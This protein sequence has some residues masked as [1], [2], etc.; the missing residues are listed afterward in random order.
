MSVGSQTHKNKYV[1][2]MQIVFSKVSHTFLE[3]IQLPPEAHVPQAENRWFTG[4]ACPQLLF[5]LRLNRASPEWFQ[6]LPN[7]LNSGVLVQ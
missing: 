5:M 6:S 7:N 3:I 1:F 2:G 4:L